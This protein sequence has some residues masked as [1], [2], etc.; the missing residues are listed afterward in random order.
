MDEFWAYLEEVLKIN[1]MPYRG[2]GTAKNCF[3]NFNNI[4][5]ASTQFTLVKNTPLNVPKPG[6]IVFWGFYLGITGLAGHVAIFKEGNVN[7]FIS[8]D[9]N[10]PTNSPCHLQ[11]HSY[12]GVLGWFTP[13]V[14]A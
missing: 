9:Q 10:F 6:D 5:G 2:W 12:R 4:K 7:G 3:N 13:K 8:F 11:T 1:P 14:K